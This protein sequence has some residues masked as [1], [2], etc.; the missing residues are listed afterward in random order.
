M[1][2]FGL[3]FGTTN[4]SLSW[5]RRDGQVA[6]CDVDLPAL[7]PRVLRS[8]LY[9]SL[10]ERDFVVGQRAISEYLR[11]DMQGTLIQSIKTFLADN[12][13]ERTWVYDRFYALEDLIA[14]VFRHVRAAIAKL[15]AGDV[16]LVVGRPSVFVDRLEKEQIAQ[17]RLRK[18]AQLAGFFDI[19]FQYEPIAAGLAYE[20]SLTAP[21]VALIADLGGGTSDFTV[22]RLGT[23]HRG[24]RRED[25][26]ATGGVQVAGDSF[27]ASI[28]SRRLT[29]YFGAGTTYRSFKGDELPFP[30]ALLAT[31]ARWHHVSFLRSRETREQLRR[32]HWTCS[33]P[34]A[35]AAL[36][37]LVEGNYAF[38]LF[39][40]IERAKSELSEREATTIRFDHDVIHI[41]ERVQRTDFEALIAAD[42]ERIQRCMHGVLQ[43]AG[44]QRADVD[45]VFLTGGSAQIPV[46]R[47]MFAEEFGEEKLKSKD[48]LTSVAVG[49]GLTALRKVNVR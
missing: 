7:N 13:F 43:A 5:A 34:G 26:L 33:D 32:L 23:R 42:R 10:D 9:F 6:L 3:D 28:M 45:A 17:D 31:L 4:S 15:T 12:S 1:E 18:A 24:E 2:Y 25:I 8:L 36:E 19:E 16:S 14:V 39:Q 35:V 41:K 48:Y 29:K 22:M 47:R 30:S 49:L 20:E 46:I 11:E 27:N 38:Y 44:L 40:E 21:E 37:A